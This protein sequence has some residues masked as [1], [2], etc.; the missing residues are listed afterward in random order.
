[1][2]FFFFFWKPHC[3]SERM[4]ST[5][6][7]NK[8]VRLNLSFYWKER[9]APRLVISPLHLQMSTMFLSLHCWG[10][11]IVWISGSLDLKN[12][13]VQTQLNIVPPL[14]IKSSTNVDLTADNVILYPFKIPKKQLSSYQRTSIL[15]YLILPLLLPQYKDQCQLLCNTQK[16]Y[17]VLV[18]FT[19]DTLA[20][21]WTVEIGLTKIMQT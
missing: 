7:S 10:S 1:M 15:M 2:S 4:V 13:L 16:I 3:D 18:F 14:P 5:T 12:E 11:P 20:S 9:N 17:Y 6:K 19:L 21:C 8:H